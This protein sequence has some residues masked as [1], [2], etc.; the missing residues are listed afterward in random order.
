MKK[1]ER[2]N[3]IKALW[4]PSRST[5]RKDGHPTQREIGEMFGLT[6]TRVACIIHDILP[7]WRPCHGRR[8]ARLTKGIKCDPCKEKSQKRVAAMRL[9]KVILRQID[10]LER[11][12]MR[13][14]AYALVC[15]I[16]AD[17][18]A[19][20]RRDSNFWHSTMHDPPLIRFHGTAL[21]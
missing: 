9:A 17:Y 14:D 15:N 16:R 18:K 20:V 8:G 13:R 19:R 12:I 4:V 7:P 6:Q 2:N 1:T 10:R 11:R 3:R 5:R 21:P